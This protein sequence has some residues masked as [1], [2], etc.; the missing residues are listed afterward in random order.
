MF[1]GEWVGSRKR[2]GLLCVLFTGGG[3]QEFGVLE[4]RRR[5]LK[6]VVEIRD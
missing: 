6:S 5:S 3:D 4:V 1:A 2:G